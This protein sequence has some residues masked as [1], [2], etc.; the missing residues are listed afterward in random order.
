ME[1]KVRILLTAI[2]LMAL[3]F[4]A[5]NAEPIVDIRDDTQSRVAHLTDDPI[6]SGSIQPMIGEYYTYRI[7]NIEKISNFQVIMYEADP[8]TG[9][10]YELT[11][12]ATFTPNTEGTFS[13]TFSKE[14][15]YL[16]RIEKT[17]NGSQVVLAKLYIDAVDRSAAISQKVA[18][19]IADCRTSGASTDYEI[20][21][22]LH[23][24]LIY[25]AYYDLNLIEHGPDGVLLKGYGVC[26]SYSRAYQMLLDGFGIPNYRE[27][28]DDGKHAWNVVQMNGKWY[29][30]DTT[31]DDPSGEE[32]AVSGQERYVYFAV[33]DEIMGRDHDYAIVYPCNSMD[34]NYYTHMGIPEIYTYFPDNIWNKTDEEL[35]YNLTH[36]LPD[37]YAYNVDSIITE[38]A[39]QGV[40]SITCDVSKGYVTKV[41][42]YEDG[43]GTIWY[44]TSLADEVFTA[45]AKNKSDQAWTG[46]D[47]TT[48]YYDF[49][50][51]A[52]KKQLV[53]QKAYVPDP[54]TFTG[55]MEWFTWPVHAGDN[56]IVYFKLNQRVSRHQK[57]VCAFNDSE[58]NW[59]G[60]ELN[61]EYQYFRIQVTDANLMKLVLLI[62]DE[63]FGVCLYAAPLMS[64]SK[65]IIPEST[66]RIEDF[67]FDGITSE[68]IQIPAG[69]KTIGHYAFANNK[70]L[71]NV[72]IPASVTEI[73]SDA[74]NGCDLDR[75]YIT[76]ETN[77]TADIILRGKYNLLKDQGNIVQYRGN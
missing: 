20:A 74:F 54:S 18:Q 51:D 2:F 9:N 75:L 10:Y 49:T 24:Y 69:C 37:I 73:A 64:D 45:I 47:N 8:K 48:V 16:I 1:K 35:V 12:V 30:I 58:D 41:E 7:V 76:V 31:W 28:S 39:A 57:L 17:Q 77:S 32:V 63:P 59:W 38:R 4:S 27:V 50:Y 11:K 65:L 72:V 33:T 71:R 40:D 68:Y 23:D 66:E 43:S 14:K 34:D 22:W 3:F 70:Q 61:D 67:A 55:T 29:Q 53:G 42:M 19:I 62:D 21:L 46:P 6:I 36:G 13:Y 15:T 44:G 52:S 5:A 25:H 60:F 26:D 56:A